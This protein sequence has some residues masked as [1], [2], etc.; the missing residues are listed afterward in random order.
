MKASLKNCSGVCP[1]SGL[2]TSEVERLGAEGVEPLKI[3]G[4]IVKM[5]WHGLTETLTARSG[6]AEP[7]TRIREDKS[8]NPRWI[9]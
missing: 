4:T 1:P 9:C 7:V 5:K 8:A 2:S 6:E 3:R